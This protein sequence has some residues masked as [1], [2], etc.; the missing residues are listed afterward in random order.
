[1]TLTPS[2]FFLFSSLLM[3]AL[4]MPLAQAAEDIKGINLLHTA[5]WKAATDD[6]GSSFVASNPLVQNDE[7]A[8][9]FTLYKKQEGKRWP[10]VEL[11]CATDTALTGVST[12]E[13][14]YRSESDVSVKFNQ[15]DFGSSGD[16]SY[17]H[18][19]TV[20][21]ASD[22]WVTVKLDTS[23]FK[24]PS[25]APEST[26]KIALNLGNVKDIYL[27]PKLNF[28][29]GETSTFRIKSLRVL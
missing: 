19:Q 8:V 20:I 24:Q 27:S 7:I 23:D 4:V 18:Y 22:Q 29:T 5:N 15:S 9:E 1:M 13:I 11:V 16:G 12:L 2:K 25:W 21:P 28:E 3:S 14:T 6:F 26:Q 17:A 10:F